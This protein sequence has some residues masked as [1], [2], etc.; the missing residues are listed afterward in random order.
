[1]S[2]LINTSTGLLRVDSVNR[3]IICFNLDCEMSRGE[4]CR[5]F[6]ALME[7]CIT[8]FLVMAVLYLNPYEP[9]FIF[10]FSSL[11]G[12]AREHVSTGHCG[13]GPD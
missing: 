12:G 3:I 6:R 4:S 9:G 11:N 8:I 1:M 13:M 7:A 5:F 10:S 2:K